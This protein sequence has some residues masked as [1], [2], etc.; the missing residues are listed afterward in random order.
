MRFA[1]LD[2]ADLAYALGA[3]D[4]HARIDVRLPARP[5]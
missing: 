4:M 1:S 2:E 5:L 3:V